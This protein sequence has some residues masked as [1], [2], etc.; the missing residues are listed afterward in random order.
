MAGNVVLCFTLDVT[1]LA[2]TIAELAVQY[3]GGVGI[4]VARNPSTTL[5]SC[6]NNFPCVEVSYETGT[7]ILRYIRSTR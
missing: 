6:S 7:H 1:E 2:I 3:A 5:F 4:I